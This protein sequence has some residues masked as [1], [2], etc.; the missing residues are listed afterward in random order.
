MC[1]CIKCWILEYWNLFDKCS[2]LAHLRVNTYPDPHWNHYPT[3]GS[4]SL[5]GVAIV[6]PTW[7]LG[8]QVAGISR[9]PNDSETQRYHL[10]SLIWFF[11]CFNLLVET[12]QPHHMFWALSNHSPTSGAKAEVLRHPLS[13]WPWN[14]K[15]RWARRGSASFRAKTVSQD[16]SS[17][18]TVHLGAKKVNQGDFFWT[19]LTHCTGFSVS[20][21]FPLCCSRSTVTTAHRS[22]KWCSC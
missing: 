16:K 12:Y 8:W 9:S 18:D 17:P 19:A 4:R 1:Q 2:L 7:H 13:L 20:I 11:R 6:A 5:A 14:S 21:R 3:T 15:F 22:R 10:I